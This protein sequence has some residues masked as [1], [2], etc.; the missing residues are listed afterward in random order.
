M[1]AG[2]A[3]CQHDHVFT[4]HMLVSL[5]IRS[6]MSSQQR[7]C[8]RHGAGDKIQ[9]EFRA[10]R[11]RADLHKCSH[12]EGVVRTDAQVA[13]PGGSIGGVEVIRHPSNCSLLHP[14]CLQPLS[15]SLST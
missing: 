15:L 7:Q 14:A 5:A 1:Q 11:G 8:A 10:E 4:H 9:R 2:T 12:E 13:V 6:Y 3:K